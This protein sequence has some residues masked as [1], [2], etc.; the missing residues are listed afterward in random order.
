[1]EKNK[2]AIIIAIVV[3][4]LLVAGIVVYN[5]TTKPKVETNNVETEKTTSNGLKIS[6]EYTDNELLNKLLIND[7]DVFKSIVEKTHYQ[8]LKLKNKLVSDNLAFVSINCYG[9]Q[10]DLNH[11]FIYNNKGELVDYF[12]ELNDSDTDNNKYR[13]NGDFNYDTN[14][15]TLTFTTDIWLGDGEESTGAG[16]DGKEF[17]ELS[18]SE[19]ERF[20]N[21]ADK[22]KYEYKLENGKFK[23]VKKDT[24]SKLADNVYWKQYFK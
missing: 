9:A 5:I 17:S 20:K 23:F 7:K 15:K 19:L 12:Y 22:V 8:E 24:L 10:F 16:F 18:A 13:Y 14:T 6:A 4:L 2:K 21:Y 11:L 3:I 1:M